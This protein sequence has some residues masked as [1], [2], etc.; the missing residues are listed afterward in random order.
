M[1][2]KIVVRQI[3]HNESIS[4][5]FRTTFTGKRAPEFKFGTTTRIRARAFL[6]AFCFVIF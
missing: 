6:G 5:F 3:C 2:Y 1:K 4:N